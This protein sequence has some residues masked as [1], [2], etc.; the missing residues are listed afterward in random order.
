[1]SNSL[2]GYVGVIAQL[3]ILRRIVADLRPVSRLLLIAFF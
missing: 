3:A 1:M 2:F